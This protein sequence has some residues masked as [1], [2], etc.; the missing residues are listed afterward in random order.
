MRNSVQKKPTYVKV[1]SHMGPR[2]QRVTCT[3]MPYIRVQ[4]QH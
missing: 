3:Q 2:T 1:E 4:V